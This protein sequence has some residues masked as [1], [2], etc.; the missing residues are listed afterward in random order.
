[1]LE[2]DFSFQRKKLVESMKL[3]GTIK[4][5][6]VEKA[7][8]SVKREFFMPNDLIQYAYLDN[9]FPIGFG[10]TISQPTT[11]A[12]SLE[13]LSV[14]NGN[15]V[16]EV[17]SGCGYVL[18]LLAELS[19]RHLNVFGVEL[20]EELVSLARQ[21][22]LHAHYEQVKVFK[23]DGN[24]GLPVYAP[25]DRIL[26]SCAAREIPKPLIEQLNEGGLIVAPLG[27]RFTQELVAFKKENNKLVELERKGFFVFVALRG[28]YGFLP[29]D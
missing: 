4:S 7:F 16:L 12:I 19:G 25:F 24:N 8:L 10:Q 13:M 9:A 28:K 17:G 2:Q 22:L 29:L 5:K 6:A 11:I 18:A 15:K 26:L 3:E 20:L 21:N 14:E 23:G 27:S 1:M